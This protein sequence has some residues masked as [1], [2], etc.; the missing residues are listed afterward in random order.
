V[1]VTLVASAFVLTELLQISFL[2]A[3]V[4]VLFIVQPPL[5]EGM[6]LVHQL[7]HHRLQTAFNVLCILEFLHKLVLHFV[8]FLQLV[9]LLPKLLV[10]SVNLQRVVQFRDV[11]LRLRPYLVLQMHFLLVF[12]HAVSQ[13]LI[14]NVCFLHPL[15]VN[16]HVY[17]CL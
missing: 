5:R 9:V 1:E 16:L 11:F 17:L 4:L 10:L 2:I 6:A 12:H 8:Q 14:P 3:F 15:G 13:Q 7:V